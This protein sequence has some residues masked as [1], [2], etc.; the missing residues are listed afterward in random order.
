MTDTVYMSKSMDS[1]DSN[2]HLYMNA[3]RSLIQNSQEDMTQGPSTAE[4]IHN[5]WSVHTTE[6]KAPDRLQQG[7]AFKM[8]PGKGSQSQRITQS[9]MPFTQNV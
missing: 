8:S 1:K 3:P 7:R 5:M 4:R 2:R 9:M 6:N